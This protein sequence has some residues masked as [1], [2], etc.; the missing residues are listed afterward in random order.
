MKILKPKSLGELIDLIEIT[1]DNLLKIQEYPAT[2]I[3][4]R[5]L[6]WHEFQYR[7]NSQEAELGWFFTKMNRSALM[8]SIKIGQI[9]F[10]YCVP[11]SLQALLH[12]FDQIAGG[13]V[14][15]SNLSGLDKEEQ[16]RFLV[17]SL[18]MEEAIT[19]AQLE[20]AST[21][22]K[23]AKD[24]LRT[25][26][27]PRNKDEIMISNNYHLL[28]QAMKANQQPLSVELILEFHRIA[29][30][31]AIDNQ[32]ISGQFRQ[33]DEFYIADRDGNNVHQPPSY[34]DVPDLIQ[35][36]CDFININ[37]DGEQ[38]RFIH[39]IIKAIILHFFIGY[40]H[41]FGDGNGRTAR[42]LFYWY[43]LKN[44]YWL[45]EY[46]SISRFL[47]EAPSKYAKAYIYTETDELDMTYFIYHQADTINKAI[48]AL[49]Q[50]ISNKQNNFKRFSSI[51]ATY[52]NSI[53][54]T[55]NDRQISILEKAVR[56][57]GILFTAKEVSNQ[58]G[59][60]ENTARK[61]LNRLLE[62]NLLGQLKTGLTLSYI[63]PNDLLERLKAT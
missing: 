31:N 55:L 60:S 42:A 50:Y 63:S 3:K 21:T 25:D 44:N 29:T 47:R 23:V 15:T 9:N 12:K 4:G 33:S 30:E 43:M 27:K 38:A 45:F 62:L 18:V 35:S 58:F 36:I 16:A 37:H 14:G 52:T 57:K 11:E 28:R 51:I 48:N 1:P 39:P 34:Q 41:P 61:D 46:L 10:Q 26:R 32:A 24:M 40:I 59:I 8:N 13:N 49:H 6:H 20:G 7:I 22:R 19:S 5:Y 2:D 56:E 54:P 17:K 53:S